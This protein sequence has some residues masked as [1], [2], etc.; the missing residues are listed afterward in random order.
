[1][2]YL[3]E[4]H[5]LQDQR[6]FPFRKAVQV[7]A[8]AVSRGSSYYHAELIATRPGENVA[9]RRGGPLPE[10]LFYPEQETRCVP[11][12]GKGLKAKLLR[13]V[14]MQKCYTPLQWEDE[15]RPA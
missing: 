9:T 10:D 12:P 7:T 15:E 3:A 2:V 11:Y 1:M 6:D 14:G 4:L 5:Y 13:S 8:T